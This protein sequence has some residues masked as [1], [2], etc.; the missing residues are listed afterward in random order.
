M[1][2]YVCQNLT[3]VQDVGLG[4]LEQGLMDSIPYLKIIYNVFHVF[5]YL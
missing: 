2:H 3:A 1:A 5:F 4:K